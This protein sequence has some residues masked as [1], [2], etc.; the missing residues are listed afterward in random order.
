MNG[1]ARR[2]AFMSGEWT[3]DFERPVEEGAREIAKVA[4]V[5]TD[6]GQPQP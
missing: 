6:G 1:S 2:A 5:L 3:E 4:T